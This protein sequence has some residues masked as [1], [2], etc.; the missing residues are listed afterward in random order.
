M[1]KLTPTRVLASLFCLS[2]AG[3]TS[4]ANAAAN[5]HVPQWLHSA[6]RVGAERDTR[7]VAISA[8]LGFRDMAGLQKLVEAQST[9]GSAQYGQ[10][11]TPA[12]FHARFSPAASDVMKVRNTLQ[13]LGFKVDYIPASGL[14]VQASGTVKQIK[15]AFHVTQD[16]Y[17]YHGTVMRSNAEAPTL[18]SGISRLVTF[19][20]GLDES[21]KLMRPMHVGPESAA[22][23]Q[24]MGKAGANP[25]SSPPP[26]NLAP[27]SFCSKYWG[28]HS[29]NVSAPPDPYPA[30]EPWLNCGYTPQQM[31]QA[32]GADKAGVDGTGV[33]VAIVDSGASPTIFHDANEYS[34]RHGLPALDSSNFTQVVSKGLS[35]RQN[36]ACGNWN[37]E[38]TLD[39]E[40]VHSMAP[41]AQIVYVGAEDC[42]D[43]NTAAAVYKV[44]DEGL[45]D[46]ITNSY[47]FAGEPL[48]LAQ[49][50]V[51]NAIYL[52]AAAEGISV[53]FSSGDSGDVSQINGVASG[54]YPATS[55]YVTAVGGTTLA[56]KDA[57]GNK[58]EWGWGTYRST[59]VNPSVN[60]D[61]TQVTDDGVSPNYAFYAGG[62]GGVSLSQRQPS[63]Q[64]GVVPK[65]LSKRTYAISGE[66]IYFDRPRRVVPDISLDADPY[67]GFL[68]GI[69]FTT[70]TQGG[71]P[72]CK[73]RKGHP[74]LE[75]CE[76]AEGGTS[77][78]SPTFAGVL[79]LV[80]QARFANGH[81]SVGFVN[82]AL[83]KQAVGAPGATDA[84]VADVQA[85]GSPHALLRGYAAIPNFVRLVTIN[86]VPGCG[87]VCEG[88]DD[89][90]LW[91]TPGYDDVT[92]LGTPYVPQLIKALK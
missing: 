21:G 79:A 37:I 58:G 49:D 76:F 6:Q 32:Y 48:S 65:S 70:A 2:M 1:S 18:P 7:R 55:P 5:D 46:I 4:A 59:L 72:G 45:A 16:R 24:H 54:S 25:Y 85:P 9:P 38:E 14:Y 20:G 69:T 15:S 83:Y 10:H 71:D 31:Q 52:Q 13:Q 64:Q 63:Y 60:S 12:Q 28:D 33:R 67:S 66:T 91:T 39:V 34:K 8:W 43:D 35:H 26:Y 68:M 84:P 77:L 81:G 29:A 80:N 40:S 19:V 87:G 51:N 3:G 56:L 74:N 89:N 82:P 27:A 50:N 88:L 11:L 41:G 57:N 23:L 30:Q 47:G 62:G 42:Y 75:Y 92:G 44:I 90:F 22:D 17:K 78:S 86:S 73:V 53:L 36:P 61:G